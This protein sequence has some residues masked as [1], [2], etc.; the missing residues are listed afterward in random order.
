MYNDF[1]YRAA[2]AVAAVAG[3]LA[4]GLW[5]RRLPLRAPLRRYTS[6]G[7]LV[8]GFAAAA[9]AA[10]G[11]RHLSLYATLATTGLTFTALLI[12]PGI[13]IA[14]TLF[15]V[16]L[17]GFGVALL[18][19]ATAEW[20]GHNGMAIAMV[21]FLELGVIA[22][23]YVGAR[24]G[25][26]A[27][28]TEAEAGVYRELGLPLLALGGLFCV[29]AILGLSQ[30]ELVAVGVL[31]PPALAAFGLGVALL[32]GGRYRVGASVLGCGVAS[33]ATGVIFAN[34]ADGLLVGATI[35]GVGLA[36]IGLGARRL[37]AARWLGAWGRYLTGQPPRSDG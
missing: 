5:L 36:L 9:A 26:A 31:C 16:A 15:R 18:G 19:G 28:V 20:R 13:N 3:V 21:T 27:I 1:G 6:G 29:L 24:Y 4:A 12:T 11:S 35:V 30:G 17:V 25:A 22:L 23:A 32:K 33:V 2:G 34:M 10:F 37:D 7:L 14:N 8:C